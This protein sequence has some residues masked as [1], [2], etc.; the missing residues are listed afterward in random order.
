[1]MWPL[2]RVPTHAMQQTKN[3]SMAHDPAALASRRGVRQTQSAGSLRRR[4]PLDTAK[5]RGERAFESGHRSEASGDYELDE[6]PLIRAALRETQQPGLLSRRVR[7]LCY[8]NSGMGRETALSLTVWCAGQAPRQ[9]KK[10]QGLV[11]GPDAY[12][13]C[14]GRAVWGPHPGE[15]T[16]VGRRT[17]CLV[18]YRATSEQRPEIKTPPPYDVNAS[19][20]PH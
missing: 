6:Y 3:T 15:F 14:Y 12:N 11:P 17:P 2:G 9:N 4:R 13:L 19:V 8:E 7:P 1:M 16:H 18:T 10:L 20:G 5:L